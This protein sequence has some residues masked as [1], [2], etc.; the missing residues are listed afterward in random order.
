MSGK[1]VEFTI[2]DKI[3]NNPFFRQIFSID[4]FCVSLKMI[5]FVPFLLNIT[6]T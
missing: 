2:W 1:G 6:K 3:T 5:I 4:S